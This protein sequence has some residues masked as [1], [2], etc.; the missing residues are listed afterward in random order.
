LGSAWWVLSIF[1]LD[2]NATHQLISIAIVTLG[3]F[4]G[5]L[6]E[7]LYRDKEGMKKDK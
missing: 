7:E 5:H 6:W 3:I 1:Y 2:W 4:I